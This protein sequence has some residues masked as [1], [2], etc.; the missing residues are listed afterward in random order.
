VDCGWQVKLCDLS[1]TRAN[2]SALKMSIAHVIKRYTK[3]PVYFILLTE[4]HIPL[5]YPGRRPRRRP[6]CDQVCD[7]D[8]V[9]EFG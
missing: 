4:G 6:V 8:S 2:L 9:M 7:L 1:L 3:R 5:R